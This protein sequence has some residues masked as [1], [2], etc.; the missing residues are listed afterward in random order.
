MPVDGAPNEDMLSISVTGILLVLVLLYLSSRFRIF[1]TITDVAWWDSRYDLRIW[2]A[3][4]LGV[5]FLVL[6]AMSYHSN[7][8][9]SLLDA[10][11]HR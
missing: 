8:A 5:V 10:F 7:L 4:L 2:P 3:L 9:K 11:V 6:L 1:K